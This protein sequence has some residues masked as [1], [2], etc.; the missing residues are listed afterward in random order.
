MIRLIKT[1]PKLSIN[2]LVRKTGYSQQQVN[3][4]LGKYAGTNAKGFQ[5]I[6]RINDSMESI[7][8]NPNRENLIE[9]AFENNY[10]DQAHF[11]HD[12][13]EMTGM[14]P[15]EYRLI[16]HPTTNRVIYL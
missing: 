13:K 3:R 5:K 7:R 8:D 16:Q 2:E 1:S 12:F 9:I 4:I 11:I 14:T 15:K 6:F 10:Y